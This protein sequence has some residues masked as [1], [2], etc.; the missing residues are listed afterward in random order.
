MVLSPALFARMGWKG[1]AGA[2]PRVLLVG[3]VA[4][5]SACI[6]FQF[7][8]ANSAAGSEIAKSE[9]GGGW[10]GGWASERVGAWG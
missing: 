2:T 4:F 6:V 10:M 5:F 8:I 7:A 9:R 1:V 3:G